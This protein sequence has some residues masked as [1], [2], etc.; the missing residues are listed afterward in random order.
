MK[1]NI[2]RSVKP[3]RGCFPAAVIDLHDTA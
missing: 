2:A 1:V 3:L